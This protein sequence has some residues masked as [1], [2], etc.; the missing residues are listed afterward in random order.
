MPGPYAH[1]SLVRELANSACFIEAMLPVTGLSS[2]GDELFCFCALGTVSPDYPNLASFESGDAV[3]ADAMHYSH[4]GEMVIRGIDYLKK[5]PD[6]GAK[7][8][9]LAWLLG[10]CAHVVADATIHPVVQ[11]KVGAYETNVQAH[12]R[13]E[14]HQDYFIAP[15]LGLG[16][17]GKSPHLNGLLYGCL[18]EGSRR[19]LDPD[20]TRFWSGL[21]L[22]CHRDRFLKQPP[23]IHA[24]H[25][26]AIQLAAA[27][28]ADGLHLFPLAR[29]I[30]AK[31]GL[32]YPAVGGADPEYIER[33]PVPGGNLMA[34][35]GLFNL[36]V[37]NVA[38][39]WKIV[40]A[41]VHTGD[42]R[43]CSWFGD[44]NLDTGCDP[45]GRLAFWQLRDCYW[46]TSSLCR[47]MNLENQSDS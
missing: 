1:L 20:I 45:V 7:A 33:L 22:E 12:R 46:L 15:R 44:W 16:A 25:R 21:L 30:L 11:L 17:I 34:Y 38:E 23:D 39:A 42:D 18:Q 40:A 2:P 6:N 41:A 14:L 31:T 9:C 28:R 43:Y 27:G 8:R 19:L 24:W 29:L 10:Y 26:N 36:A 32:H 3:W 35:D 47:V 37:A 13:C 4:T 5:M